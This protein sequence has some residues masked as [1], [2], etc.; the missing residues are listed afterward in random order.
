MDFL[1]RSGPIAERKAAANLAETQLPR[2]GRPPLPRDE[3]RSERVV[4]FVTPGQF[5]TLLGIAAQDG[6]SVS[7]VVHHILES[8]LGEEDRGS[9]G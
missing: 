1:G 6:S 7:A 5:Q 9:P 8:S 2:R 4:T 3:A